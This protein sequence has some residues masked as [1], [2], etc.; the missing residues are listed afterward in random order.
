MEIF[1]F[2]VNLYYEIRTFAPITQ[3]VIIS[4]LFSLSLIITLFIYLSFMR[5][6]Y[7]KISD[8]RKKLKPQIEKLFKDI[9]FGEKNY[10]ES[11]I[12]KEYVKIV[13]KLNSENITLAI[14]VLLQIKFKSKKKSAGYSKIVNALQF[15]HYLEKKL[16]FS[17]DSTKVKVLQK[18]QLL[19]LKELDA[20]VIPLAYSKNKELRREARF[21]HLHL[22]TN[23]PYRFLDE[24]KG[25]LSY[26]DEIN[27]MRLL[28]I[29]KENNQLS[30]LGKWI[31]YSDNI[32]L[33]IFLIKAAGS[34]KQEDTKEILFDK[35]KHHNHKV[36]K[37]AYKSLGKIHATE[38]EEYLM[39]HFFTEHEEC[40]MAIIESIGEMNTGNAVDFLRRAFE[41][42]KNV[43]LK[44]EVA[45]VTYNY[46][47]KYNLFEDLKSGQSG[48]DR[49]IFN[50]IETQLIKFK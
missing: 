1:D 18:L 34:F 5:Y 7:K 33:I 19:D 49:T 9:L 12:E 41:D 11:E 43:Q 24:I 2:F 48:F 14:D 6:Y 38:Y 25:D 20:K 4:I 8:H 3:I 29:H 42:A 44:K 10:T 17:K 31:N 39:N 16:N 36:R 37:E 21:S 15:D 23:D 47:A 45:L 13:G 35:L 30:N 32:S 26:W 27:L 22:S 50:H 28:K 40:Q 46:K